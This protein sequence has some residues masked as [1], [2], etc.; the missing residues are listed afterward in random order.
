MLGDFNAK[1]GKE[2]VPGIIGPYGLGERNF[3]GESLVDFSGNKIFLRSTYGS[4]RRKFPPGQHLSATQK[5]DEFYFGV[6]KIQ[7]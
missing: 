5:S 4:N 6:K 2:R 7:E 3:N 1:V